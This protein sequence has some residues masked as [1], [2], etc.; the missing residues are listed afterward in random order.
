[1]SPEDELHVK[2]AKALFEFIRPGVVAQLEALGGEDHPVPCVPSRIRR[3]GKVVRVLVGLSR[4]FA[5]RGILLNIKFAGE[6]TS[7][8][9]IPAPAGM[10]YA[11]T[12]CAYHCGP[13]AA[14]DEVHFR[15]CADSRHGFHFHLRGYG[16]D[17]GKTHIPGAK[18]RPKITTEPADFLRLV[19]QFFTQGKPPIEVAP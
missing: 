4:L 8:T 9:K 1:M 17:T 3:A 5:D 11:I 14:T 18:A 13:S 19:E 15:I 6:P 10:V 7:E 16:G 2:N 12:Q